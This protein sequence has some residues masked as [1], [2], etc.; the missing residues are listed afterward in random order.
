M[1]SLGCGL[2]DD[3]FSKLHA[4]NKKNYLWSLFADINGV[5]NKGFVLLGMPSTLQIMEGLTTLL[6]SGFN[7]FSFKIVVSMFA[8]S[9]LIWRLSWKFS[10]HPGTGLAGGCLGSN[11]KVQQRANSYAQGASKYRRAKVECQK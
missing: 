9:T 7:M 3:S 11:G 6:M 10:K 8:L 5:L 2:P 1:R 4:K